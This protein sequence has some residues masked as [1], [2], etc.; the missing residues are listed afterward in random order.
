MTADWSTLSPTDL[1]ALLS[2]PALTVTVGCELLGFDLSLVEDITTDLDPAGSD[3]TWTGAATVHRDCQITLAR[4]LDWGNALVRIYRTYTD[5]LSGLSA[6]ADR[7]VF[8]LTAPDLTAGESPQSWQITGQDRNYFLDRQVGAAYTAA[9]G[10]NVLVAIRAAFTAAGLTG[11]L[12]DSSRSDATIPSDM[13]WPL[14]PASDAASTSDDTPADSGEVSGSGPTTWLQIIN[15]LLG[16]IS[17]RGVWV[18]ESGLYRCGPYHDPSTRPATFAFD[19]TD[20]LRSTVAVGQVVHGN[21]WAT[22]TPNLYTFIQ[23]NLADSSDGTPAVPAE[24]AGIY[25]VTVSDGPRAAANRNGLVWPT[26][27]SYTA[28]SQTDLEAQGDARVAADGRLTITADASTV[29]FPASHYDVLTVTA[30]ALGGTVKVEATAWTEPLDGSD[31][32]WTWTVIA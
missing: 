19:A 27:I 5:P 9:A 10:T 16:L 22:D 4:Q 14:I 18:D 29:P 6:R 7:G 28:A 13:A 31:V 20:P 21:Y 1:A 2:S 23:S 17:Y 15:Q 3:V 12:I 8:C 25:T 24:G 30:D 11:V 26:Q 32:Q